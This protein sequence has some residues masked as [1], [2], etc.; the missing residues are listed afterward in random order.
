[1]NVSYSVNDSSTDRC[2]MMDKQFTEKI[3]NYIEMKWKRKKSKSIVNEYLVKH[4][5]GKTI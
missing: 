3:Q 5:F 2:R 4:R 1:M